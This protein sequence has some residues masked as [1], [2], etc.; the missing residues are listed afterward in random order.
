MHCLATIWIWSVVFCVNVRNLR[1][2]SK[3]SFSIIFNDFVQFS[4]NYAARDPTDAPLPCVTQM[5]KKLK[6]N[7]SHNYTPKSFLVMPCS[8]PSGSTPPQFIFW[9]SSSLSLQPSIYT[10][11]VSLLLLRYS[12]QFWKQNLGWKS[13]SECEMKTGPGQCQKMHRNH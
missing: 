10:R 11:L 13:S 5:L 7:Y 1:N 3:Q 9:P 12:G 8:L 2:C 6:L 4:S